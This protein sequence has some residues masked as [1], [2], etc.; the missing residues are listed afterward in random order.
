M[1]RNSYLLVFLIAL[2]QCTI[3]ADNEPINRQKIDGIS[4]EASRELIDSTDLKPIMDIGVEW[5]AL[6]PYAFIRKEEGIVH[7]NSPRQWEG[8]RVEGIKKDIE[9]CHKLGLKVMLKPHVWISRGGYTGE[10]VPEEAG[11][12]ILEKS[13]MEYILEFVRLAK[14]TKVE[15]FCIGTEWRTF[16]K[17]RPIYWS[18][19]IDS[20]H[21]NYP[22]KLT[23]A[24]N[25]DEYKETPFWNKLDYIGVNAYFPL[26]KRASPTEEDLQMAWEPVVN[27]LEKLSLTI[28]KPVLFTE[29]GYRSVE[30]ATIKPWES[31]TDLPESMEEQQVALNGLYNAVWDKEWMAGGFLWKWHT[32]PPH[33]RRN[34]DTDYTPQDKPALSTIKEWYKRK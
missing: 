18:V 1:V 33:W 4:V 11:W 3:L 20:I 32:Q 31:Y 26:G 19:L 29:Y 28:N 12:E 15:M 14:D 22:G 9:I 24:A 6:M 2:A 8:E 25:W 16:I 13:Y 23:Y 7:Y 27:Q 17:E 34:R 10:Y 21:W 5:V 30:G